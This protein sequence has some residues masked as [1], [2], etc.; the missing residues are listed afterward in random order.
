MRSFILLI[1]FC[2][3]PSFAANLD[4]IQSRFNEI[5]MKG[6][7]A[8]VY[9]K[10]E[11]E[12]ETRVVEPEFF[13][14]YVIPDEKVYKYRIGGAGS[15]VIVDESGYV[16]TNYH[17]VEESDDIKVKVRDNRGEKLYPAYYVG[18]DETLDIAIIKIK[19]NEK[20]P[21]IKFSDKRP[22]VGDIVFAIGYPFGYSQTF[23]QGVVSGLEASL[24]VEGRSYR[25]LIQTDAAINQGNSGG[26]LIN[27]DGEI[28]GINTAIMSPTGVF[29]GLGFAIPAKEAREVFEEVVLGKKRESAWLG[30]SLLHV[31]ALVSKGYNIPEGGIINTIFENSPAQKAGL[32][33]GDVI[34]SADGHEIK[35]DEDLYATIYRKKPGDK[36]ML[37]YVRNGAK[38]NVSVLLAIKPDEN[39]L[40]DIT[41]KKHKLE[42]SFSWENTYFRDSEDGVYVVS[43]SSKSSLNGYL[44]EGDVIK[45]ING[46]KVSSL[47]ELESALSSASLKNGVLFDIER[48]GEPFYLSVQIKR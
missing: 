9:V 40:K 20:F 28:S 2:V 38:K 24:K 47:R 32:R 13:F 22:K 16:V 41:S 35:D 25:D 18:G 14:G 15:G 46:V 23:T 44:K 36:L 30:V 3:F 6:S 29:A 27:I 34:V 1:S 26:P 33:R 5:A 8:V 37:E 17:V 43:V 31:K 12:A 48:N 45:G 7:S 11:K 4:E 19:S 39:S 21:Y 10:V 42:N